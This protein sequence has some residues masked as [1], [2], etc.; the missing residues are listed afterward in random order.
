M[1]MNEK[2]QDWMNYLLLFAGAAVFVLFFSTSTSPLYGGYGSDSAI[3]QVIGKYWAK[4]KIPYLELFDHKG[5]YIFLADAAG[6]GIAQSRYGIAALQCIHLF[7]TLIGVYKAALCFFEKKSAALWTMVTLGFL[8][9]CYEG[10]NLTEEFVLP[11]LAFSAYWQIRFLMKED[12][13]G[14]G[15]SYW[16]AFF[17]GVTFA[18]CVLTRLTNAVGLCCGIFIILCILVREKKWRNIGGCAASVLAG[19]AAAGLPFIFY[20]LSKG[21]LYDM[22]LGTILQNIKAAEAVTTFWW[23]EPHSLVGWVHIIIAHFCSYGMIGAGVVALIKKK[24]EW[25]AYFLFVGAGMTAYLV[26]RYAFYHYMMI[27]IPFLPAVAAAVTDIGKHKEKLRAGLAVFLGIFIAYQ[28]FTVYRDSW[29]K[30]RKEPAYASLLQEIPE[31]GKDSF[32]AYNVKADIYLLYGLEPCSK[33]FHHQDAQASKNAKLQLEIQE[34]YGS[35]RAEWIL[36]ME[37]EFENC[38]REILDK[39]YVR[40]AE[41]GEYS[42]YRRK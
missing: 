19:T 12:W 22:F 23:S 24:G 21:A 37:T 33:Y 41:N 9:L 28:A 35:G 15:H 27:A 25:A 2:R 4:G 39:D 1:R 3:F 11:F 20:F 40:A 13:R 5:P 30:E 42:L 26:T 7:F 32:V 29:N 17:Y 38:I 8:S 18:L 34:E 6:Y 10:G 14:K 36:V 16:Q 31:E